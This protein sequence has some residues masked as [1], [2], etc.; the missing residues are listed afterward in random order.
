MLL[1]IGVSRTKRN[2]FEEYAIKLSLNKTKLK[3]VGLIINPKWPWLG[4]S[5]DALVLTLFSQL[6]CPSDKRNQTLI[7][8]CDNKKICLELCNR[9]P[10]LKLQHP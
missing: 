5:P 2:A 9:V 4:A 8:A 1:V 7:N 6:K 3:N 10:K